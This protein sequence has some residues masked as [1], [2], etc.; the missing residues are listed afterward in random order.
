MTKRVCTVCGRKVRA[1]N[2]KAELLYLRPSGEEAWLC[3]PKCEAK[4][5]G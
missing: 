1:S 4:Y 5:N 2:L 3:G